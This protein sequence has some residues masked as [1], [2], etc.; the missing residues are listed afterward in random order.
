MAGEVLLLT[1]SSRVYFVEIEDDFP[2]IKFPRL[3]K[4]SK[5]YKSIPAKGCLLSYRER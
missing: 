4:S 3:K 1:D 5:L 2:L